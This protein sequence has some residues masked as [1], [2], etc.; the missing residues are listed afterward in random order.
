M[1]LYEIVEAY[2][3]IGISLLPIKRSVLGYFRTFPFVNITAVVSI[4][5]CMFVTRFNWPSPS[6]RC[7]SFH[8]VLKERKR[9]R[10]PLPNRERG[11]CTQ[12]ACSRLRDSWARWIEKVRTTFRVPFTFASSHYLRARLVHRL[13]K[14][15]ERAF[16]FWFGKKWNERHFSLGFHTETL[17]NC[18]AMASCK[19]H[20]RQSAFRIDFFDADVQ[21]PK[22]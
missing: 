5:K 17:L 14:T 9:P 16:R 13:R 21:I 10:R 20:L 8:A 6:L 3:L 7:N 4:E 22:T 19:C 18:Y 1:H 2:W 15:A 12:I 11:V